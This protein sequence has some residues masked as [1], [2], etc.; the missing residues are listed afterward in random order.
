MSTLKLDCYAHR[1]VKCRELLK[2]QVVIIT[3][4]MVILCF[5]FTDWGLHMQ[6]ALFSFTPAIK[7]LIRDVFVVFPLSML[8]LAEIRL[9]TSWC[10]YRQSWKTS[11]HAWSWL[12]LARFR[13][14]DQS[15]FT[16]LKNVVLAGD[17]L[18]HYHFWQF[19]WTDRN[20]A[21]ESQHNTVN[22]S[23]NTLCVKSCT[24]TIFLEVV[25]PL[26]FSKNNF[27]SLKARPNSYTFTA[28]LVFSLKA[29]VFF[30]PQYPKHIPIIL[31]EC[32]LAPTF[33]AAGQ[34]RSHLRL[35]AR[36]I[37][38]MRCTKIWDKFWQFHICYIINIVI[39]LFG[40]QWK[41]GNSFQLFAWNIN[42][43]WP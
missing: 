24:R 13:S 6:H 30:S 20:V 17:F 37:C 2:I 38:L 10:I 12:F 31:N 23:V 27:P 22:I 4:N 29:K 19:A 40:R 15:K 3:S 34:W 36:A 35:F 25:H 43:H 9:T 18:A 39:T 26:N 33:N 32:A 5:C 8:K 16:P 42:K 41:K 11:A 7:F 14:F 28:D 1:W 21:R